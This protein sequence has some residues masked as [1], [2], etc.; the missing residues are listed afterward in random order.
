MSVPTAERVTV[1][2][3][4]LVSAFIGSGLPAR[5][6]RDWQARLFVLVVSAPI[7]AE[8]ADV[9]RRPAIRLRYD[10][11]AE[12][13]A[14]FLED[15]RVRAVLVVPP[16][17]TLLPLHSRDP[18]D[19]LF[20]ACALAGACDH[21]VTGDLDLLTLDRHPALGSL[22]IVT[23]RTFVERSTPSGE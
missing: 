21:L 4:V 23:P 6:V 20:L 18:K 7:I 22:R 11:D 10:L 2:T 5:V 8:Y 16:P 12:D 19:D 14:D 9:L 1:D 17:E 3:T 15:I 13:V